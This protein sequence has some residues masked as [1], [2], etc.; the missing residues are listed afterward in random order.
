[1]QLREQGKSLKSLLRKRKRDGSPLQP[2]LRT[3]DVFISSLRCLA[4]SLLPAPFPSLRISYPRCKENSFFSHP[5]LSR[6]GKLPLC[7]PTGRMPVIHQFPRSLLDVQQLGSLVRERSAPQETVTRYSKPTLWILLPLA[8]FISL[9]VVK[10]HD[11]L[12]IVNLIILTTFSPQFNFQSINR[13]T[14][15]GKTEPRG[16]C[17][18]FHG[19]LC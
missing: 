2:A 13:V 14:Y 17:D 11:S 10:S 19:I 9:P 18:D 16:C 15:I 6:C 12:R 1:M 7:L 5:H 8:L 4:T 3:S